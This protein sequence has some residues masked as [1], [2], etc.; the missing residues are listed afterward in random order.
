MNVIRHE[1]RLRQRNLYKLL[2]RFESTSV[3]RPSI[4]NM[5]FQLKFQAAVGDAHAAEGPRRPLAVLAGWLGANERQMKPYLNFYHKHGIDTLSFAVGPKHILF[6]QQAMHQMQMVLK[7]I[8]DP[9]GKHV[10]SHG[11]IGQHI[12]PVK[13]LIFHHFSVGGFLYG[14]MLRSLM[15]DPKHHGLQH[16]IKAQIFDSPPDIQGIPYGISKGIGAPAVLHKAIEVSLRSYLSLTDKTTGPEYRAS[17]SAFHNNFLTATPALWYYSKSDIIADWKACQVVINK[18]RA[19]GI[20]VT[21]CVWDD[22]PH[23]QHARVDPERYFGTLESFLNKH[24]VVPSK[25]IAGR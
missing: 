14:Q 7:S 17:S 5:G 6:P 12:H 22:T 20:D 19:L 3:D 25:P 9:W 16:C 8:H 21:E 11:A 1:A 15:E 23:I 24:N 13:S 2:A 18:W 4:R 10:D